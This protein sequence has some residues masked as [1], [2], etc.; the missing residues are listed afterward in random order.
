MK[1]V[2]SVTVS[3]FYRFS[4]LKKIKLNKHSFKYNKYIIK[5]YFISSFKK[6]NCFSPREIKFSCKTDFFSLSLFFFFLLSHANCNA[7][8]KRRYNSYR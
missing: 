8:E 3:Q 2:E 7:D 1:N 5:I 6:R 4:F